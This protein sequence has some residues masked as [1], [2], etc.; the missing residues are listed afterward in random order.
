[1]DPS[2]KDPLWPANKPAPRTD[3][4]VCALN[5]WIAEEDMFDFRGIGLFLGTKCL[6]PRLVAVPVTVER[7][8]SNIWDIHADFWVTSRKPGICVVEM[9]S[10]V[11]EVLS[12]GQYMAF[13]YPNLRQPKLDPL[14]DL[15]EAW[16]G[17]HK[18]DGCVFHRLLQHEEHD[19]RLF[20]PMLVVKHDINGRFLDIRK[21][22]I[23]RALKAVKSA[24]M[25]KDQRGRRLLDGT[26]KSLPVPGRPDND[27]ENWLDDV[28]NLESQVL[29]QAPE[30]N[31]E[32]TSREVPSLV[33]GDDQQRRREKNNA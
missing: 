5:A 14:L 21:D 9:L 23:D 13:F 6:A 17:W 33:A 20:G 16:L 32:I 4:E 3:R 10:D 24:L 31:P 27:E 22:D 11:K 15:N 26:F 19:Y 29:S 30:K 7:V 8:T 18:Q 28:S 12:N 2:L 1:M 25:E